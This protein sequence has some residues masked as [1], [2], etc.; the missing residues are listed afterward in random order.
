[1]R[2]I[3]RWCNSM[4]MAIASFDDLLRA[5]RAQPEPQRLLFVFAKAELPDDSTPQQRADFL[6]GQ[7]G[8]LVPL[9]SVDKPPEELD[10]FAALVEESRAFGQD[11]AIVFVA[12]L[13]GSAGTAPT[14][15]EA[16]RSL[17]RMIEAI[18]TGAFGSF[19]PFDRQGEPICFD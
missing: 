17:Q 2:R 11:W 13:S 8:T 3:R 4:N 19:M 6:E 16:E 14:S 9:M 1:M 12:G 15:M 7:G 18:K 10:T 5:A